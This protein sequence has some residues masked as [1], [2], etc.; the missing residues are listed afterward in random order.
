MTWAL[1]RPDLF[2]GFAS[3]AGDALFEVSLAP[4]LAAAAQALRNLYG[5]SFERF[6]ADFRSGRPVL[7][8]RTD[9][10]ASERL[11]HGRGLLACRRRLGRAA[12]P[13]RHR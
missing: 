10:R 4:E 7:A 3:H 1:R 6:W 12:L 9:A 8:N 5:G 11:R 2:G 13:A